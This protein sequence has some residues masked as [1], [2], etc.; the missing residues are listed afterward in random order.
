MNIR[1][2]VDSE[3]EDE[4]QL[5]GTETV[6][7]HLA[8]IVRERRRKV[9]LSLEECSKQT[10]VSI[11]DLEALELGEWDIDLLSLSRLA[12]ALEV[13]LTGILSSLELR[14][15]PQLSQYVSG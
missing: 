10:D 12:D 4:N 15:K 13:P 6:L 11:A 14:K 3:T 2:K 9:G 7:S 1:Q 5:S 8:V